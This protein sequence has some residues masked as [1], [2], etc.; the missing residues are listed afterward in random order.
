MP[1]GANEWSRSVEPLAV[2]ASTMGR[3]SDETSAYFGSAEG[4]CLSAVFM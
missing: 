2:T 4:N 3:S 1:A